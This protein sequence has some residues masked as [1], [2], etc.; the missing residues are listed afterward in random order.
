MAIGSTQSASDIRLDYMNLLVTQLQN[1]NP[2]EPMSNEDMAAQLAQF[3]QLE[4]LEGLNKSFDQVL[5][6]TERNF[7]NS[8]IGKSV[9]FIDMDTVN[10]EGR[11]GAPRNGVVGG[12]KIEGDKEK[13]IVHEYDELANTTKTYF[14]EPEKVNSIGSLN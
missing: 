14:I 6:K 5:E 4:Q 7:A 3:T 10:S 2:M 11:P 13:L 12:V 1:Q 8:L 9:S